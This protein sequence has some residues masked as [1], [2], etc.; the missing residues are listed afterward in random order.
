MFFCAGVKLEEQSGFGC[1]ESGSFAGQSQH[2][3]LQHRSSPDSSVT[4]F[5]RLPHRLCPL[6]QFAHATRPL[7]RGGPTRPHRPRLVASHSTRPLS[8]LSSRAQLLHRS[9][10]NKQTNLPALLSVQSMLAICRTLNA[11]REGW[12][13]DVMTMSIGLCQQQRELS[14]M[15]RT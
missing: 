1:G 12:C 8:S 2:Q 7:V 15:Y 11:P 10:S 4:V 9:C 13:A 5:A 3:R 6:S 14:F